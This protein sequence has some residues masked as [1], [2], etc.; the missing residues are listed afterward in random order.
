MDTL[1]YKAPAD[2]WNKALPV[3]NGVM[4]AMCFG[5][6]VID[7]FQLN[8]DSIWWGGFRDRINPDAK[9]NIPVI[10]RLIREGKIRAAEELANETVAAVPDYQSHYEPLADVF[11]IPES[12]ERIYFLGLRDYWSEQL[13]RVETLPDYKREL[14]IEKG[15]HTVSYTKNSMHFCR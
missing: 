5:G 7:R 2:N 4:G 6:T 10:Q 15:I 12:D 8:N 3:G 11:F 1:W 13:N 14:D 9:E